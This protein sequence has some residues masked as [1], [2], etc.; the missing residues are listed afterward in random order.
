VEPQAINRAVRDAFRDVLSNPTL[1]GEA[2]T[3]ALDEA[4]S[5]FG[6]EPYRTCLTLL[7]LKP[8]PEPEARDLIESIERHRAGLRLGL[9]RDPGFMV[10]ASD[11]AHAA[12]GGGRLGISSEA[13]R[14]VRSMPATFDERLERELRRSARSGLPVS[15]I[16]LAPDVARGL[17][18]DAAAAAELVLGEATRDVDCVARLLPDGLALLLP[19]TDDVD[20]LRAAARLRSLVSGACGTAWSAGVA[21]GPNRA[22]SAEAFAV[23]ALKALEQARREGGGSVCGV[24]KERRRG[25]RRRVGGVLNGWVDAGAVRWTGTL[26]DLS[27][28]GAALRLPEE[29]AVGMQL[30]LGLR[31]TGARA[32]AAA[33]PARVVR[34]SRVAAGG[35]GAAWDTSLD[36]ATVAEK[37]HD[38]VELLAV[39][40]D[41]RGR[42]ARA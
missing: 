16:L 29:L 37:R 31:E 26:V 14:P 27:P 4:G 19:C 30:L 10:A 3:G 13:Q 42:G 32:R 25:R 1:R 36:F 2:L 39:V 17:D 21:S 28:C 7:M 8:R 11:L 33:I 34:V 24:G 40:P 38:V 9:D 12:G 20:G 41:G 18:D 23:G 15:L 35:G 22:T 6:V 5:R